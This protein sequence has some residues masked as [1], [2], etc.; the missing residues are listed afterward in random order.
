MQASIVRPEE[1]DAHGGPT[2][3]E[4]LAPGGPQPAVRAACRRVATVGVQDLSVAPDEERGGQPRSARSLSAASPVT[5]SA[6]AAE[7]G[8]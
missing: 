2:L 3:L 7:R 4:G 1:H 8:G 5:A 6:P